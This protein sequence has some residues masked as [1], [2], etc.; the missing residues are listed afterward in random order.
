MACAWSA[1]SFAAPIPVQSFQKD[2]AGVTFRMRTGVLKLE[3]CAERTVHVVYSPTETIPEQPEFVVIQKWAP[4]PFEVKEDAATV[5][6]GTGTM[7]VRVNRLSGALAF[8]DAA[9]K[10]VL[11]EPADGG[12]TMIPA[13]VNNE[14]TF[15]AQQSFV[16][17]IDEFLY[18]MAQAQDGVWNW[19][20]L[21]IEL[22]QLNAQTALPVLISSKGYGLLWD[23]ASLTD[24]NPVDDQIVLT[25]KNA[26]ATA[27]RQG[28]FTSGDAG[29][30]VFFVKDGDR[31][32]QIG[33]EMDGAQIGGITN[34]W[35]PYTTVAKV[36]L[37]ANKTVK[38]RLLGGGD[39]AKLFARPLGNSTTFRSQVGDK[40]D[41]YFFFGP[42]LDDVVSAYR[43]AT[44]AAPLW[45][46][47]AYGFWQC[48]ER[49]SSQRQLLDVA[50]QFR[51]RR[52]PLDLIVQDWQYWGPHGWGAYQWDESKYP[53]PAGLL[54]GLHDQNVKFMISVWSNPARGPVRAELRHSGSIMPGGYID[55]CTA[56]AR[57]IRWKYLNDAFYKIG[58][59]AFWQD[60]TEPGDDGNGMDNNKIQIGS[61]NRY[62]NLYP[63][64]ANQTVYEGQRAT[65][66][67]KRVVTLTRSSF[68]G[69]QRY[70]AG[71]WS[72]DIGGNW[73]AFA[74]QIP[75]GLNVCLTGLP[76]WTTDCGGFFRPGSGQ[77][78]SPDYN[79]L[80]VRWFQYSAFS[81]IFRVH[82]Y[83]T[84]TEMWNYPAAFP[85][86]LKYDRLRYRLIPYI[87]SM[88]WKVTNDGYTLMRALPMDFRA[89]EKV[90]G[91]SDQYMFG[92]AFLVSPVT[93]AKATSRELYLPA[94]TSWTNFWTGEST[95]GG[96]QI[97]A[98]AP[99]DTLPLFI[100][101]GSIVP[102]GP[103][104]QYA[105]EKPADPLE[106]RVYPGADGS[107][108]LYEDQGD[109][110]NYEQGVYA[111]IDFKWNDAA[112]TL[113][114][115]A[116]KGEFPG[117]LKNRTFRI[118]WVRPGSGVGDTPAP[119]PDVE[120][121]Y[122][123][124][125]V[126]IRSAG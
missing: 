2:S 16:S 121:H 74:K 53:D 8:I 97:A 101:A 72:G 44:G 100:R 37:P 89:D 83:Q 81:P 66:S 107:F 55:Q 12:K 114:V 21:P 64:W 11:Q 71:I 26:A 28:T 82:G 46:R 18:G 120:I 92:S 30:Y 47:W 45:P 5:S 117:M 99:L 23:N 62:R 51:Q 1:L 42:E 35:V 36:H 115:A 14:R 20:G 122:T 15:T 43:T 56:Q 38:V 7:S 32:N 124:E 69:Q 103:E 102:F 70:A 29:D 27:P 6:L 73:D 50:A 110:Y 40:I 24:F 98:D 112:K 63:L 87:Y 52:I 108:T 95:P 31:R 85:T 25:A 80:L 3:V 78:A 105:A 111:T 19:R 113:T 93:A 59:D 34:H 57:H 91:I 119:A 13:T 86:L 88:A 41:Y 60:A 33:I 39:A 77:F 90:Y 17:P 9:G 104:L 61:G 75:A 65:N 118:A 126:T 96:K 116:R 49:Y 22:R 67:A 79:E 10:I 68:P 48:R 58:T 84:E 123:G 54:K 106:I 125:A 4:V 109:S 76:Y 94:S